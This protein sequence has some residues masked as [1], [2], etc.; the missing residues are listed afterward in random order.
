[1]KLSAG[2]TV[3]SM[4]IVDLACTLLI[5]GNNGIGK[6]TPFDDDEGP[7]YRVQSRGGKGTI[8][9]KTK[10]GALVA[11]ALAVR[12]ED[13]VMLL[14]K[15]G[16]AI[17]TR[18]REIRQTGRAASGVKLM[19]LDAGEKIVGMCKVVRTD[20]DIE[21]AAGDDAEEPAAGEA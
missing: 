3:K 7:V 2:D 20:E 8:A 21:A 17:R 5:A 6:R 11:G 4:E 10:A 12:D 15:S 13:E 14:T 18:V 16:Q 19:D 9:I 1:M